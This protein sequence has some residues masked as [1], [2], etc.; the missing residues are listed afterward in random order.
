MLVHG[1]K[2]NVAW[3]YMARVTD[4]DISAY[5]NVFLTLCDENQSVFAV[6]IVGRQGFPNA[7]QRRRIADAIRA[8]YES[9]KRVRAV[10]YVTPELNT[11]VRGVLTAVGWLVRKPWT[12]AVHAH[13]TNAMSWLEEEG[14]SA[15]HVTAALRDASAAL[16]SRASVR[17]AIQTR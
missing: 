12:E 6:L 17:P 2:A 15:A 16:V 8:N 4:E 13:L 11:M 5:L 9:T 10:A 7:A 1:S 3:F 14:A